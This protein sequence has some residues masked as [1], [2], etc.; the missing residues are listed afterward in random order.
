MQEIEQKHAADNPYKDVHL[1]SQFERFIDFASYFCL[2]F[3]KMFINV[4]MKC[5]QTT[6]LL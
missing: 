3:M 2:I 5:C 6:Y 4:Q 1:S